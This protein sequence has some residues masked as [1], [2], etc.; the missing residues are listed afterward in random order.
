[1]NVCGFCGSTENLCRHHLKNRR[2]NFNK[3]RWGAFLNSEYNRPTD[4]IGAARVTSGK[5]NWK[6]FINDKE[7][8][9]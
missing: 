9:K 8:Q 6:L 2:S 7:L 4:L 3:H 5:K 1:M